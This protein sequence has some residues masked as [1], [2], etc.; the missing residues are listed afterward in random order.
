MTV[1]K[2]FSLLIKRLAIKVI[3]I[4]N[5]FYFLIKRY[6]FPNFVLNVNTFASGINDNR[7]W[8]NVKLWVGNNI[9]IRNERPYYTAVADKLFGKR[10]NQAK[11]NKTRKR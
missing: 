4:L 10:G 8:K 9:N 5:K 6:I 1:F 2:Y 11:L 3:Q 7:G